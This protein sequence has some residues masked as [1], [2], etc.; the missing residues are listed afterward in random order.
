VSRG[1]PYK[2][3]P[4][5]W[6]QVAW[7]DELQHGQV[8][9]LHYFGEHMVCYR[10]ESGEVHVLDAVC[11]HQGAHLGYG[12]K[13]EGDCV[14]CPMHGWAWAADGSNIDIPDSSRDRVKARLRTWHV[15]ERNEQIYVWHDAD[16]RPPTWDLP[17]FEYFADRS[18]RRSATLGRKIWREAKMAPQM[19]IEN[20]VDV[21]HIRWVHGGVSPAVQEDATVRDHLFQSVIN[22]SFPTATGGEF[23]GRTVVDNFGV[24]ITCSD[25]S[26]TPSIR[27][28]NIE[29]ATPISPEVI[30]LRCTILVK[31]NNASDDEL[32]EAD[33]RRLHRAFHSY[34]TSTDDDMPIWE[35]MDY[36]VKAL[37]TPEEMKTMRV[38]RNWARQFYPD[39]GKVDSL[40]PAGDT[41]SISP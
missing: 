24:G 33:T 28:I 1:F 34:V 10:T 7:S 36:R 9:P 13:V 21:A 5:G 19:L 38:L 4:S 40:I 17:E 8:L 11:A 26:P 35:H 39:A 3:L 6:F 29:N 41:A 14:R 12:G 31:L 37:L 16:Q 20:T 32:D 18:Y 30:D 25:M 15:C 23:I 27:V 22:Q 2:V